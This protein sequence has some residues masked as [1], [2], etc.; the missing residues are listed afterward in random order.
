M[1]LLLYNYTEHMLKTLDLTLG[2][3]SHTKVFPGYPQP[4]F[5]KW[6]RYDIQ[7]YDSET[8]FLSTHTGTH[9]DAPSHFLLGSNSIDQL[10]TDRFVCNAVLFK[11]RRQSNQVITYK[12]IIESGIDLKEKDTAVFFTGWAGHYENDVN[13]I[14]HNP[15]LSTDAAKY[16]VEKKVNAVAIDSPGIDPGDDTNFNAHKI[17]LSNN[18]LIIENLCNLEKLHSERF[19]LVLA[20]LKLIGA[21]GSP[22]RAIAIENIIDQNP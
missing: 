21:S 16:L 18:I 4:I 8:M 22:I 5:I 6:S 3:S 10:T 14:T 20:P 19:M 1:V 13:Y 7:G 12:N 15:G 2:I 17:L 9:M 11:L